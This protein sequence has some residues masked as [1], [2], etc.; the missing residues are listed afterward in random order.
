MVIDVGTGLTVLGASF[1]AWAWVVA[2]G[3]GVVRREVSQ[4]REAAEDTAKSLTQHILLTEKRLT[5]LESEFAF[6]RRYLSHE[7]PETD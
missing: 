3:V 6:I 5:M 4:L 7:R 1:A 2:W